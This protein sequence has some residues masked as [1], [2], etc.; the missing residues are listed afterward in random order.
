M[1][2]TKLQIKTQVSTKQIRVVF[3]KQV[4]CSSA[5]GWLGKEGCRRVGEGLGRGHGEGLE[6][7][8]G[9]GFGKDWGGVGF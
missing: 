8:W 4:F 6:R 7:G 9:E 1:V 5:L 3:S 2:A